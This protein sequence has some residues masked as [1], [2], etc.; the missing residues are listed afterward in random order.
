MVYILMLNCAKI[1]E[2]KYRITLF[3]IILLFSSC[4]ILEKAG[5]EKRRYRPGYYVSFLSPGNP[6]H[7]QKTENI[8]DKKIKISQP[9][10]DAAA[11]ALPVANSVA[12]PMQEQPATSSPV[13]AK[14]SV[15]SEVKEFAAKLNNDLPTNELFKRKSAAC[16]V[17]KPAGGNYYGRGCGDL[18]AEILVLAVALI[19]VA[20]FPGIN[21]QVAEL[22]AVAVLVFAA[23]IAFVL[24]RLR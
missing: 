3:F 15:I 16:A 1:K 22:I 5:I 21:P 14:P 20:L 23:L 6:V 18:L 4:S 17:Q 2:M 7:K 12:M 11:E 13:K 9:T 19:I 8:A 24:L 10:G